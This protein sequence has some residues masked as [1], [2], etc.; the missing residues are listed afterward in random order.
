MSGRSPI[1][2]L[3]SNV[4]WRLAKLTLHAHFLQD[5]LPIARRVANYIALIMSHHRL[6]EEAR[7]RQELEAHASKLDLLDQSLASLAD[8]GQ[9][10]DLID[11]ISKIIGQ[12]L[13]PDGISVAVFLPNGNHARRYVFRV[14]CL[15]SECP[16]MAGVCSRRGRSRVNESRAQAL[17]YREDYFALLWVRLRCG[18]D[19]VLTSVNK[20]DPAFAPVVQ[21]SCSFRRRACN[22]L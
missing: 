12:V 22:S 19:F 16:C 13:P 7:R 20:Y 21:S 2:C 8:T 5:D 6:A 11:P 15:T 14:V 17:G 18:F 1:A 10:K 3:L 9:L 4:S